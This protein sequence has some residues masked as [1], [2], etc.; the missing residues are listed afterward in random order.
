MEQHKLIPPLNFR[1]TELFTVLIPLPP[2]FF[3][4]ASVCVMFL[5]LPSMNMVILLRNNTGLRHLHL[6]F[7]FIYL[8]LFITSCTDFYSFVLCSSLV[9]LP[10]SLGPALYGPMYPC[11]ARGVFT[12]Q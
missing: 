11:P 6:L 8:L 7:Y 9:I 4:S 12:I 3:P 10:L 1:V 5:G 2:L